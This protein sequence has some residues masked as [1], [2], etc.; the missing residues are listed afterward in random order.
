MDLVTD[1]GRLLDQLDIVRTPCDLDLLVFFFRHPRTLLSSDQIAAFM[2]Y[3]VKDI[4]TSLELLLN[5]GFVSRTPN[6][7]H[8]ARMY[9]FVATP[10]GGESLPALTRLATTRH[11]RLALIDELRRR[12][13]ADPTQGAQV[14]DTPAGPLPFPR[15]RAAP[16]DAAR[17]TRAVPPRTL[18]EPRMT[19]ARGD[20]R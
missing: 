16:T 7:R 8:A 10:A 6:R 4:A 17:Q 5:A 9:L 3:A 19:H 12:C 18:D 1:A 15:E 20:V 13:S 11:G 14:S 2:G